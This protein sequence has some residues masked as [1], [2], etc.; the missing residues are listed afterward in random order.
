MAHDRLNDAPKPRPVGISTRLRCFLLKS[1]ASLGLLAALNAAV[2]TPAA[3]GVGDEMQTFFDDAGIRANATGPTAFQGQ[4]AGYYSG[5]NIWTRFPQKTVSPFN[6]QLP[7]ARAGCG[8][9]DLFAGSFS[10]I[11]TAE[12]VAMLKATANNAIGFAFQLAID[13]ISPQI[14]GVIKDMSQK[15]QQINQMNI[16]SCETAQGLFGGLWPKMDSTRDSI[17]KAVGNSQ[18]IFSD[19]AATRQG[20]N[21]GG[22]RDKTIAKNTNPDMAAQLVGEKHNFTWDILVKSPEF[23]GYDQQFKELVMTV[24]GTVTTVPSTDLTKGTVIKRFGPGDDSIIEALIDGSVGKPVKILKCL[25]PACFDIGDQTLTISAAQAMRPRVMAALL[26]MVDAIKTDSAITS[27]DVTLLN[28]ASLP[29]YK[30]IAVQAATR[31]NL[32]QGDLATLAEITSIDIVQAILNKVL[33]DFEKAKVGLVQA[34]AD[35]ADSWLDQVRSV[36]TRFAQ[37][38]VRISARVET[39]MRVIDRTVQLESTLQ[40]SMTPGMSAALNFSRGLNP[41]GL[42]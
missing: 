16:S 36:R 35:S 37:R 32:A 6:L 41:Q 2:L 7:H 19:W 40:N 15:M 20:C 33:G 29:L 11:N 17:C 14:S 38:E 9:I 8:G 39:T 23:A 30:I 27:G 3:A 22:E 42:Q 31:A 21:N 10:F 26:R 4:S 5:G 34:D 18:G 12:L 28:M 13:A 25:D 24:I 1:G